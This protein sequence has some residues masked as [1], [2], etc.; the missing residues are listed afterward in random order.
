MISGY[1]KLFKKHQEKIRKLV[2]KHKKPVTKRKIA[3]EVGDERDDMG[4]DLSGLGPDIPEEEILANFLT[5]FLAGS[6]YLVSK[7][8]QFPRN[9]HSGVSGAKFLETGRT[10]GFDDFAFLSRPFAPAPWSGGCG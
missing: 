8:G 6:G 7:E 2:K 3:V 5:S 1:R 4:T 10:I 9:S